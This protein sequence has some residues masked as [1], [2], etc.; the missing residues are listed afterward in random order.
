MVICV[1]LISLVESLFILPAHLAHKGTFGPALWRFFA[2]PFSKK[3]RQPIVEQINESDAEATGLLDRPRQWFGPKLDSFIVKIYR[4]WVHFATERRYLVMATSVVIFMCTIAIIASGRL[5]FIPLPKVEMDVVTATAKLPFGAPY[6]QSKI[7]CENLER[8]ATG[9]L[10]EMDAQYASKGI[11][12]LVGMDLQ[13]VR[14]GA[15]SHLCS[16]QVYLVSSSQREFSS[17]EFSRR[18][19][20]AFPQSN[21]LESLSFKYQTGPGSGSGGSVEVRLAH[22]RIDVLE[23]AATELA[24]V[25]STYQGAKDIDDGFSSGKPQLEFE[26]TSK[27]NSLGL[28]AAGV[29]LQ[30][31]SAFY[32]VEALRQQRGRDEV[33]VMVRRP[34]SERLSESE[35]EKMLIFTPDG[36]EVPLTDVVAVHRGYA[37]TTINRAEGRRVVTV[38]ADVIVGEGNASEILGDLSRKFLPNLKAKYPGLTVSFEGAQRQWADA[39]GSLKTSFPVALLVIFTLLAIPFKSYIQPIVVMSAIPF[40]LT[41]AVIGHLA[42]GYAV[43]F[44]SV[45][46]IVAV[47][48]I[49]VNDSLVLI[50]AANELRAGGTSALDAVRQAAERRFRPI[51]LTSLTTFFGLIPMILETSVQARFLIPM[52]ISLGFGVIFATFII[53]LLVPAV[54]M[55]VEDCTSF[56]Y[57]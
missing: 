18:W 57:G 8:A 15:A 29:G 26:L 45:M 12:S 52:A 33:R 44:I 35:I 37:F 13:S 56:F 22:S 24:N 39:V 31:R 43:S 11:F 10:K 6:A 48:G 14:S 49:V 47:S 17:A 50:H 40:G 4:P 19:R 42:M 30:I 28:T 55:A 7:V 3:V 32:G 38:S 23:K 27:A 16:S 25:L 54:Y 1:L 46:G 20:L 41:G 36:G 21:Q 9:V 51:L 2:W 5:Q 34:Q 53:L